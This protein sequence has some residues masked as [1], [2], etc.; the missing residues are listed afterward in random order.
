VTVAKGSFCL[1]G[2]R[3]APPVELRPEVWAAVR[4]LSA[5]QREA[6]ALRYVL[7]LSEAQVAEAMGVAVGTASATLAAARSR[8]GELLS[9]PAD[10]E[11]LR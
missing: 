3:A 2:G 4:A 10:D 7:D 9:D 1:G 11:V 5:R 8:L 6:I